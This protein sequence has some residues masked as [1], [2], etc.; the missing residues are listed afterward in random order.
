MPDSGIEFHLG[1][2]VGVV[3]GEDDIDLEEASF[4]GRVLG[5]VDEAFPVIDIVVD[6]LNFE[7][8]LLSL[9][10]DHSGSQEVLTFFS[11]SAKS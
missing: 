7:S 3:V 2:L 5:S 1:R 10:E 8:L 11:F 6:D 9:S 4:I